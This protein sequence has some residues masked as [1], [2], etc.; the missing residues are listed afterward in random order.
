MSPKSHGSPAIHHSVLGVFAVLPEATISFVVSL[1]V[2]QSARMEQL[3]CTGEIC[4]KFCI[5]GFF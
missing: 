2:R 1:S 4:V 5:W 3:G